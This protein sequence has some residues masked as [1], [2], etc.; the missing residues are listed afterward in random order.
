MTSKVS[1]EEINTFL[2]AAFSR[3]GEGPGIAVEE[4]REDWCK[5]RLA[6]RDDY[7]RPG[8]VIAGPLQMSLADTATYIAVFTR[9]GIV[10]GAVTSSLNINFLNP[11][12]AG[13]VIATGQLIKLGKRF[14]VAEVDVREENMTVPASR[15]TVTFTVP[16]SY[17]SDQAKQG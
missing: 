1:A 5:L 15:A 4:V 11:C 2:A 7:L 12:K 8:G 9:L 13:D 14:A 16:S 17:H 3:G 6:Y 10:P